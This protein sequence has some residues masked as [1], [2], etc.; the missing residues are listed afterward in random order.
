[1]DFLLNA[2]HT[3]GLCYRYLLRAVY[4]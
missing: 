4:E 3:T 1:L 2:V